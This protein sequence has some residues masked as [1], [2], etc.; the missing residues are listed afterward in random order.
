MLKVF[1]FHLPHAKRKCHLRIPFS[2]DRI[3]QEVSSFSGGRPSG[4]RSL[5]CTDWILWALTGSW[6]ASGGRC[7]LPSRD[8]SAQHPT[9]GG[10]DAGSSREQTRGDLQRL[11]LWRSHFISESFQDRCRGNHWIQAG[12][13]LSISTFATSHPSIL[14]IPY[15]NSLSTHSSVPAHHCHNRLRTHRCLSGLWKWKSLSHVQLF[16]TPWPPQS[17]EFFRPEYWSG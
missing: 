10:R 5:P 14:L 1:F 12:L 13:Y 7:G 8:C 17:M 4:P 2:M 6:D 15:L 16:A 11:P 9:P 3:V